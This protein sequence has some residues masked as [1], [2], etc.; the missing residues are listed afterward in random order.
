MYPFFVVSSL[1]GVRSSTFQL[2][3]IIPTAQKWT[4]MVNGNLA[5]SLRLGFEE[6]SFF[7]AKNSTLHELGSLY[8]VQIYIYVCV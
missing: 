5:R 2:D 8:G 4:R 7:A 3:S 6:V 1:E